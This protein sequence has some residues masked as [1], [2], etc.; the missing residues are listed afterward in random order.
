MDS[1]GSSIRAPKTK[2]RERER[3][4]IREK[5][6][7]LRSCHKAWFGLHVYFTRREKNSFYTFI[8]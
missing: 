4:R 3:E 1:E 8:L 7:R 6:L 2:K 5:E